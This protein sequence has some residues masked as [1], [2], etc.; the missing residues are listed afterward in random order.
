M[1]IIRSFC[2]SCGKE[3]MKRDDRIWCH[4]QNGHDCM[5]LVVPKYG[6]F[7]YWTDE[8]FEEEYE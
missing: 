2:E 3:I 8:P 5:N 4:D 7:V 1:Q 6:P